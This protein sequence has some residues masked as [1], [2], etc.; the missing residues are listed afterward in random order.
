MSAYWVLT[1][2]ARHVREDEERSIVEDIYMKMLGAR[3]ADFSTAAY[4]LDSVM[5]TLRENGA[6]FSTWVS[7]I[8]FGY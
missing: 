5:R 6:P 2:H 7:Y 8:H 4:I 1:P 3:S